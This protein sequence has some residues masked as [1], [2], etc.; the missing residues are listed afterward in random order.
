[1]RRRSRCWCAP[2]RLRAPRSAEA[3]RRGPGPRACCPRAS[4]WNAVASSSTIASTPSPS[5]ASTCA[6]P[7]PRPCPTTAY[8]SIPSPASSSR[9]YPACARMCSGASSGFSESPDP[10]RSGAITRNRDENSGMNSRHSKLHKGNPCRS[11]TTGPSPASV[12]ASSPPDVRNRARGPSNAAWAPGTLTRRPPRAI[13]STTFTTRTISFTSCTRTTSTPWA[14]HHATAPAVPSTRSA[15]SST[16]DSS[17]MKRFRLA[18]TSTGTR[19]RRNDA[20][21]CSSARLCAVVFPKPIPGSAQSRS[22]GT[23]AATT[24]SIRSARKSRTSA[25]TSS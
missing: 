23:P 14:A 11:T 9:T 8:R 25:T 6:T 21:S 5:R 22:R 17:P 15:G 16:P 4:A 1:M 7:P 20:M 10:S 12:Y 13:A 24:A 19:S 2:A 3:R 18:P